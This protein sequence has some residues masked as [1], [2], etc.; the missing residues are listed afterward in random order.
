MFDF[1]QCIYF[2]ISNTTDFFIFLRLKSNFDYSYWEK[3]ILK[4]NTWEK[5]LPI[6][7]VLLNFKKAEKTSAD[8]DCSIWR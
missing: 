1:I 2:Q 5:T 3:H 8:C 6:L 4:R 7:Q